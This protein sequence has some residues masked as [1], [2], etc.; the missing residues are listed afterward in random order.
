MMK[1]QIHSHKDDFS[2]TIVLP[3]ALLLNHIIVGSMLKK[4]CTILNAR[5]M[6]VVLK[7]VK[8]YGEKHPNFELIYVI[9]KDKTISITL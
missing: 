6:H 4:Y 7:K 5:S 1:I 8:E 9:H 3:N 2:K